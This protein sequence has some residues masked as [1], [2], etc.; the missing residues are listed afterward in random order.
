M[1]IRVYDM[2][3]NAED[4]TGVDINSFVDMPAHTRSFETYGKKQKS[5]FAVDDEKRIVTG[6]FIM[7]DHLIYR[8][9]KQL[10]EH[11]VKFSPEVI[12]QIRN[13]FFKYGFNTNTNV[14]HQTMVDGAILVDSFIVHST[15]P[16]FP[17]VPEILAKQKVNDGSWVGSYHIENEQLWQDC[18]NGIFTGFS[19][20]GYFDKVEAKVRT[21]MSK[22]TK[23]TKG[24][25]AEIASISKWYQTVDQNTFEVGTKLTT[26][27]V[28][29]EGTSSSTPLSAGEYTTETGSQILV[30]SNGMVRLVYSKQSKTKQ[31]SKQKK[32][33]LFKNIF[34]AAVVEEFGQA[35]TVDG[36]VIFWE[37]DLAVGTSVM[38]E[39]NG[40]KVAAP[41]GDHQADVDGVTYAITLDAEGVVT[42]MEEV[43]AM[44]EEAEIL[45]A[46]MK[47]IVED[48]KGQ[49]AAQQAEIDKLKADLQVAQ[50]GGKFSAS[51]KKTDAGTEKGGFRNALK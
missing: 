4:E 35:T 44:S 21:G 15:D 5:T 27:Y 8:N 25:F 47:K 39:V 24:R 48:A 42:S 43:T 22:K 23:V 29:H 36:V 16:R 30:D 31:M 49:F 7:A 20:E 14:Q 37:G 26:T 17:K 50:A 19:V 45:S 41:Q 9:D 34:G 11:W 12:W 33:S 2:A 1:K 46:A 38:I 40:E 6:V 32:N 51:G 10:G 3:I 18:K 13:K 28:D